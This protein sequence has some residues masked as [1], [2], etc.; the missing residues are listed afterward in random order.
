MHFNRRD[1]LRAVGV[2]LAVVVALSLLVGVVPATDDVRPSDSGAIPLTATPELGSSDPG[3]PRVAATDVP[4][5]DGGSEADAADRAAP[6]FK[7]PALYGFGSVI[8]AFPDGDGKTLTVVQFP[9]KHAGI[10]FGTELPA[11]ADDFAAALAKKGVTFAVTHVPVEQLKD[12]MG[13]HG[14]EITAIYSGLV[15]GELSPP[16]P[17]CLLE[18]A[19]WS[20][21]YKGAIDLDSWYQA[22]YSP[23]DLDPS[24]SPPKVWKWRSLYPHVYAGYGP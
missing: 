11:H 21:C 5:T 22:R 1:D 15:K 10:V 24:L 18:E 13:K 19:T 20:R 8:S 12:M 4:A 6:P 16:S 3:A 23:Q 7:V 9:A 17:D 14:V 2:P